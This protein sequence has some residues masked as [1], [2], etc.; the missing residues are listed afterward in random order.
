METN[1]KL[2][3]KKKINSQISLLEISGFFKE[4][5]KSNIKQNEIREFLYEIKAGAVDE[6]IEDRILEILDILEGYCQPQY[7]VW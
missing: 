4:L 7:K 6:I 2:N 5:K 1:W 3:L